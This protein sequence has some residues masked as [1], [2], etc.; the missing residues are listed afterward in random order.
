MKL[1]IQV[2]LYID[3]TCT[4]YMSRTP[5][6]TL[7]SNQNKFWS[8]NKNYYQK[9]TH[10]PFLKFST[11]QNEAKNFIKKYFQLLC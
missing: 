3:Q 1:E 2:S 5:D 9:M 8:F 6:K 7:L 4:E 10:F 11:F